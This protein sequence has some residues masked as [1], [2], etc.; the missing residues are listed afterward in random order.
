MISLHRKD[1]FERKKQNS[2]LRLDLCRSTEALVTALLNYD[3]I[4]MQ[5]AIC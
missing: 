2:Y 3:T 1:T 4:P 5:E